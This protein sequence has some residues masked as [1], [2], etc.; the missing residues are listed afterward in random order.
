M[1]PARGRTDNVPKIT[2]LEFCY[3]LQKYLDLIK[4]VAMVFEKFAFLYVCVYVCV[5]TSVKGPSF[6]ARMFILSRL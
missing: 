1:G 5:I 3:V 6:G 4:I 2:L